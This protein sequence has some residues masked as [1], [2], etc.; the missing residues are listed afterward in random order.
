MKR[1][2]LDDSA[3]HIVIS[4]YKYTCM[5]CM[6]S[7]AF[8][9]TLIKM[10]SSAIA[11][12]YI[13]YI[14]MSALSRERVDCRIYV[15]EL[16][17]LSPAANETPVRRDYVY[18]LCS[19]WLNYSTSHCHACRSVFVYFFFSLPLVLSL[20]LCSYARWNEPEIYRYA[21]RPALGTARRVNERTHSQVVTL[22]YQYNGMAPGT[23]THTHTH[24]VLHM[25]VYEWMTW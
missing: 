24:I 18:T 15:L 2:G 23:Q 10:F 21:R 19:A 4:E 1:H 20:L 22:K 7:S 13:W 16:K 5:K 25:Y 6:C 12:V 11:M 9:A 14:Y 3:L 17:M 8:R